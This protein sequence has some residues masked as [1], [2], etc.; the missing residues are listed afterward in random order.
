MK[1]IT[2]N[3]HKS[4]FIALENAKKHKASREGDTMAHAASIVQKIPL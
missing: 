3:V 4:K 2:K 1:L